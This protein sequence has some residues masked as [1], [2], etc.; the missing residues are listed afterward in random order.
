MVGV[1]AKEEDLRVVGGG[2]VDLDDTEGAGVMD[3][4]GKIG[5]GVVDLEG[6]DG[7]GEA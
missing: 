2:V 7:A 6:T 1:E 4:G 5:A 3:L